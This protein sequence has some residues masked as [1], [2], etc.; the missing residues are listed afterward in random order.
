[1]DNSQ[2]FGTYAPHGFVRRVLNCTRGL[3][4]TWLAQRFSYFLR[5]LAIR[6]LKG[7]PLDVETLGVK[8]R[9]FPYNNVCEKR[10]LFAPQNFDSVELGIL[11]ERITEGF[12]FIDVGANI[13]AYSLFVAARSDGAARILAIEPQP[14][15]FDRLVYNIAQNPFGTI[16]AFSCAVA[17]KPGE[18]TLFLDPFNRG[19]SSLKIVGSSQTETIRVPAMPLMNLIAGEGLTGIDAMK[20]DA[21]GSEDLILGPFFR[22]AESRLYPKLL[23]IE[24]SGTLWQFDIPELLTQRGYKL[25][26]RT[27]LNL[28]YELQEA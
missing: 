24:D 8:M 7:A 21:E 18:L 25:L 4:K 17:D 26:T 27:R 23:I 16:K 3:P 11:A 12:R 15:I 5:T 6:A 10:I 1:M 13:G 28:I 2:P 9:L 19:E 20:I 14:E 22:D